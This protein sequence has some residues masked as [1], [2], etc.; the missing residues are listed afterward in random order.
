[1]YPSNLFKNLGAFVL[2]AAIAAGCGGNDDP[3]PEPQPDPIKVENE[4]ALTQTV[5]AD[6]TDGKS[7]VTIV[8][9]GAWTS[10]ITEGA[11]KSTKAGTPSWVSINPDHGNAAR[12]YAIVISLEPNATGADRTA[13]VTITCN[14]MDISITVTQKG[15]KEDDKPYVPDPVDPDPDAGFLIDAVK[16]NTFAEALAAALAS[17][18][19]TIKLMKNAVHDAPIEIDGKIITFDLNGKTLELETGGI[20]LAVRNG[21]KLSLNEAGGA[22]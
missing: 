4:T 16:Y 15:T 7:D 5:Y 10:T 17:G 2:C 18:Y 22:F 13:T 21:G 9:T 3:D 6:Q 14:G 12:T 19:K 1:M 20:A 11:A 8:T